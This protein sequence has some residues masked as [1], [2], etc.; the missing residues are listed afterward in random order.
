MHNFISY[1]IIVFCLRLLNHELWNHSLA[2]MVARGSAHEI[3]ITVSVR[4]CLIYEPSHMECL[5]SLLTP[6][7]LCTKVY[8]ILLQGLGC[9]HLVPPLKFVCS[10]TMASTLKD[11]GELFKLC[12]FHV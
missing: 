5:P 10:I 4:A 7:R 1:T 12:H 2:K 11:A 6:S 9:K 3:I 8:S